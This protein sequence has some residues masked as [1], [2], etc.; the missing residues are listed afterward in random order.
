MTAAIDRA[1]IER[2][3]AEARATDLARSTAS[4]SGTGRAP[5]LLSCVHDVSGRRFH[6][7]Y[8]DLS[9]QHLGEDELPGLE[10]RSVVACAVDEFRRGVEV[11]LDDGEVTSF[12]GEYP[13]Y[14][15]DAAYRAKVDAGG[16]AGAGELGVRAARRVR[17]ARK[18]KG[19]SVAELARRCGMAAPNVHRVEAAR[20]VPSTATLARLAEALGLPLASLFEA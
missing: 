13:R 7:R 15:H 6:I 1:L 8:V 20:H 18:E 9:S 2:V 11:V 12:S 5:D 14:R 17:R 4:R 16:G 10:G 3:R 19:W